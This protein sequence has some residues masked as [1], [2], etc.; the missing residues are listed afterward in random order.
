[1]CIR[2]L[3]SYDFESLSYFFAK[4]I[5]EHAITKFIFQHYNFHL[6]CA[7][8]KDGMWSIY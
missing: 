2:L 4:K 8:I 3:I 6:G 1:M 5:E 7:E